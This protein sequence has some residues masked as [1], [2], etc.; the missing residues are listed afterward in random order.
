MIFRNKFKLS[1]PVNFVTF[2][3]IGLF[4]GTFTVAVSFG[5]FVSVL[6]F[7]NFKIFGV[8]GLLGCACSISAWNYLRIH[9]PYN[10]RIK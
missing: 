6:D 3:L 5:N 9:A 1:E 10:K 7:D 4:S 8:Y 2:V